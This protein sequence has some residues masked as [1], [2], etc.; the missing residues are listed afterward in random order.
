MVESRILGRR[1]WGE[2]SVKNKKGGTGHT[3]LVGTG[4]QT[5]HTNAHIPISHT[6]VTI[7]IHGPK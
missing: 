6:Y 1:E 7:P 4:L 2:K 5:L 3:Y